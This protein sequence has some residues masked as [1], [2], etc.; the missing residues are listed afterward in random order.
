MTPA[1]LARQNAIPLEVKKDGLQQRQNGD[2]VLRFV[3]QAAD[4]DQR[5]TSAPMGT[6]FQ[7]VLVEID[8]SE[9]PV[10]PAAKE[11]IATPQPAPD[12]PPAAAKRM[13][14]RELQPAAQAGIRCDDPVFWKFLH[15]EHCFPESPIIQNKEVAA[16]VIRTICNVQSRSELGTNHKARVLW[17]QLDDQFQAWKTYENA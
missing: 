9:M 11:N 4:M 7:V 17:K 12:K 1:D 6:R 16:H 3:V 2:W 8:D 5:L 10:S 15:V 13:D 14:W